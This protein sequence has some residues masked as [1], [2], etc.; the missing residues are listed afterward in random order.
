MFLF[1][2]SPSMEK[3]AILLACLVCAGN[4]RRVQ[5]PLKDLRRSEGRVDG[6]STDDLLRSLLMLLAPDDP[7][8]ASFS[9]S[10]LGIRFVDGSD[11]TRRAP[12][13]RQQF[14]YQTEKSDRQLT[15]EAWEKADAFR[16]G[17]ANWFTKEPK[18]IVDLHKNLLP[19]IEALPE[20]GPPGIPGA[21]NE[22]SLM[23]TLLKSLT[24]GDVALTLC[25]PEAPVLKDHRDWLLQKL[26]MREAITGLPEEQGRVLS[27]IAKALDARK[28]LDLGTYTGYSSIAM[29]LATADDA[30]VICAEPNMDKG[31]YAFEWWEKAGCTSKMEMNEIT[32]QELMKKML[33]NG[34]AGS[35]DM[36]FCDVGNRDEYGEVHELAMRLLRVGGVV[37]YYD[38]LWPADG[39]LKHSYYPAMRNFNARLARDPRVIASLVPLSY[40][41]TICTKV[42]GAP[43]GTSLNDARD[44]ADAGNNEP[45]RD[46]LLQRRR[47]A[48]AELDALKATV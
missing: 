16:P 40:G 41:I 13:V 17:K 8:I 39:V 6:R 46:L 11:D 20:K 48:Q 29:A 34:E 25:S 12:A 43:A 18:D 3:F 10:A 44:A 7:P 33:E 21:G 37:I 31:K 1:T 15:R 30:R 42:L 26:T 36:I 23:S 24:T 5:S 35:V 22:T 45:L 28:L 19:E 38:T 47:E 2:I 9:P 32:A 27:T 4:G 14:G